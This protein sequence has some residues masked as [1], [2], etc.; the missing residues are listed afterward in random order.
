MLFLA[1]L[2]VFLAI[3][4]SF[5]QIV[6]PVEATP[7]KVMQDNSPPLQVK[8]VDNLKSTPPQSLNGLCRNA[9]SSGSGEV[10]QN[11]GTIREFLGPNLKNITVLWAEQVE[12]HDLFPLAQRAISEAL[13]K[14]PNRLYSY[15]PWANK[16]SPQ[17]IA[18]LEY[19]NGKNGDL[20]LAN[21][22]ACFED[23]SGKHWWT[24]FTDPSDLNPK[25]L[26][27]GRDH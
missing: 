26:K 9:K 20:Q 24:R 12:T 5:V 14:S 16:V 21:G 3:S 15:E 8:F 1:P 6:P 22:Y 7:E 25:E 18:R 23:Q 4:Y 10:K 17:F 11:G 2:I 19:A 27:G 13:E